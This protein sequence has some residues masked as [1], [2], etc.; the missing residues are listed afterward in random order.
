MANEDKI[1][2]GDPGPKDDPEGRDGDLAVEAAVGIAR[3]DL[4][5]TETLVVLFITV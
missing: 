4:L 5:R 1:V 3:G 2:V